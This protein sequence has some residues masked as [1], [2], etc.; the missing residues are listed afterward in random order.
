[1]GWIQRGLRRY[2][3]TQGLELKTRGD[4]KTRRCIRRI[5]PTSLDSPSLSSTQVEFDMV[6]RVLRDSGEASEEVWRDSKRQDLRYAQAA[7]VSK[8]QK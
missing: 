7:R 4:A 6:G 5:P 3:K 8:V 1:V 2:Q